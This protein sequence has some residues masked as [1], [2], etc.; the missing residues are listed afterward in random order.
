MHHQVRAVRYG[1]D[2]SLLTFKFNIFFISK[3][4]YIAQFRKKKRNLIIM[5]AIFK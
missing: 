2:V 1:L 5:I 3:T 4:F